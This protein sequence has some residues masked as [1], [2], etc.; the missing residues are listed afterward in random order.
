MRCF[1]ELEKGEYFWNCKVL[2]DIVTH[3]ICRRID[4][5]N[6][7]NVIKNLWNNRVAGCVDL[8]ST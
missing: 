4:C 8:Y 2:K 5:I 7:E 6:S 1:W 3:I